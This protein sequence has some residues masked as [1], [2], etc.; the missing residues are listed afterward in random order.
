MFKVNKKNVIG[1]IILIILSV[2]I[3]CNSYTKDFIINNLLI[4]QKSSYPESQNYPFYESNQINK[5]SLPSGYY[6]TEGYVIK[7]N[8][9][10]CPEGALCKCKPLSIIISRNS[11]L[12]D[13]YPYGDSELQIVVKDPKEFE[14]DQKYKFSIKLTKNDDQSSSTIE[15]VDYKK[16]NRFDN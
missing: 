10:D 9:C 13:A 8:K 5:N 12:I 3:I 4:L 14:I 15:L 16:I 2:I 1:L 11:N 6:D 7:Q